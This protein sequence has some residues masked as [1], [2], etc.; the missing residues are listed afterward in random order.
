MFVRVCALRKSIA[1][2]TRYTTDIFCFIFRLWYSEPCTYY[3]YIFTLST[4]AIFVR[5]PESLRSSI[6][7][8]VD[9]IPIYTY[10]VYRYLPILPTTNYVELC[11][12]DDISDMGRKLQLEFTLYCL[13]RHSFSLSISLLGHI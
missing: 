12:I 8:A 5:H 4:D 2:L 11:S 6:P 10:M 13:Y 3:R 1:W 9:E 7:N